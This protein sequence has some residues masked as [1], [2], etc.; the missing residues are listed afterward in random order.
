MNTKNQTQ[1]RFAQPEDLPVCQEF[2]P[3]V[4]AHRLL[5]KINQAEIIVLES[6]PSESA[7]TGTNSSDTTSIQI[8]GYLRLEY[9]WSKCP[10]IGSIEVRPTAQRQGYGSKMLDWLLDYLKSDNPDNLD[11][12]SYNYTTLFSSTMFNNQLSQNRHRKNGFEEC[13]AFMGINQGRMGE[14]FFKRPIYED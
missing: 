2:D 5:N 13:G 11:T 7:S 4:P 6:T 9:L 8:D 14:L 12:D 1:I 10:F 3:R